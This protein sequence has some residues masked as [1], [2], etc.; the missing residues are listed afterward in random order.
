M[1][2]VVCIILPLPSMYTYQIIYIYAHIYKIYIISVLD[3][4][5]LYIL[6][7]VL[8]YIYE[9]IYKN[10]NKFIYIFEYQVHKMNTCYSSWQLNLLFFILNFLVPSDVSSF[11][12]HHFRIILD[13]QKNFE[14]D[15]RV[16]VF[17]THFLLLVTSCISMVYFF[18]INDPVFIQ[19]Y[20]LKSIH[21][22]DFLVV[23]LMSFF[24]CS[25]IPSN[26]PHNILMAHLLRL[27]LAVIVS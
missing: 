24:P 18:I 13:V 4:Y 3:V 8:S 22:S 10:I 7:V 15:I 16:P 20:Y 5:I 21:F 12:K 9:Y 17:D 6:A 1:L 2:H 19:Y 25:M 23:C 11:N 27:L 14:D 26:I